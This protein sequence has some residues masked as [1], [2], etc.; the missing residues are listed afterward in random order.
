MTRIT[1]KKL[2]WDDYNRK[3]IKNHNVTVEDVEKAGRNFLAH[4]RAKKGR[5][6]IIGRVGSR[7][8]T[9]IIKRQ[10]TGTYYPITA[11]DSAK[12]ERQKVYEKEE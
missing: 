10:G 6:M 8:I 2:I 1:V 11:R 7:M 12:K 3:H 5:Y 9:V 4:K